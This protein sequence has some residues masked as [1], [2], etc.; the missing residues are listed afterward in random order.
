MTI[1][2]IDATSC[3]ATPRAM[4]L[5]FLRHRHLCWQMTVRDVQQRYRGSA[6]GMLWSFV[7]PML[8]LGV[9]TVVF[10]GIFKARWTGNAEQSTSDVALILFSGLIVH[11]MLSECL[12]RAPSII[13]QNSSF[14]T[15]VVFPLEI[16]A[17]ML[18][19]SAIFNFCMSTLI[20]VI[21]LLITQG[22]VPL[23]ALYLPVVLV[24]LWLLMLGGAWL[25]AATGVFLRDIGQMIGLLM[26][27]LL[28]LSPV[29]YPTDS[30]PEMWRTWVYFNPLA[31]A[32]EQVRAVLIWGTEPAWRGMFWHGTFGLVTCFIG[33]AW[34]QRTRKAFADVL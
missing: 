7:T 18:V 24:P 28:F 9:Y 32:I 17:P 5:S 25:L 12:S 6:L 4:F 3:D 2:H 16:L 8:M 30:L 33:F 19:L 26:T 31:F 22:S 13:L 11:A 23:T 21:G 14:V 1:M 15:K 27:I 10:S 20:L 34:F 29:F